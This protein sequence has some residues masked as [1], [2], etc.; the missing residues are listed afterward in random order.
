MLM[1]KDARK[2][3]GLTQKELADKLDISEG[4][5]SQY[6]NGK[7]EP[8]FETL[9]K[10]GELLGCSTDYLLRGEDIKIAHPLEEE[11]GLV[12]ERSEWITAWDNASPELRRA[13]LAVLRSGAQ[14]PEAQDG[15]PSNK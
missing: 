8:D 13:A 4:A 15:T 1:F 2:A 6:E 14:L 3:K 7:R 10:I 5:L 11:D 9:L 12:K